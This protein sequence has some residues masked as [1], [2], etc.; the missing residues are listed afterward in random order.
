M[1]K[2][3][4][5]LVLLVMLF[6]FISYPKAKGN[7]RITSVIE[8]EKSTT[9]EVIGNPNYN[10]LNVSFN[11]RF[12]NLN[13]YIKYKIVI[14]NDDSK[15]YKISDEIEAFQPSKYITY[16]YEFDNDNKMISPNSEKVLYVTLT[17]KNEVPEDL[18]IE[19]KTKKTIKEQLPEKE[20]GS[21]L[22]KKYTEQNHLT[23]YL[24]SNDENPNTGTNIK[25]SALIILLIISTGTLIIL[26]TKKKKKI[27]ALI[28][29]CSILSIPTIMKALD[30]D[31][32]TVNTSIEI[33]PQREITFYI[34]DLTAEPAYTYTVNANNGDNF[35]EWINSKYN[36][37]P[38]PFRYE[39][40][41]Y[42]YFEFTD[43]DNNIIVNPSDK[44][45]DKHTYYYYRVFPVY[46]AKDED[47]VQELR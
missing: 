14:K 46:E 13:D 5:I 38:N 47:K 37:F 41:R 22:Y 45:K 30:K 23:I 26:S 9:T 20:E 34:K 1:K 44:I 35:I 17:Y 4:K 40:L 36:N 29:L 18:L 42:L 12:R 8:E 21:P 3:T 25:I 24:D 31:K 43:E 7:I 39:E 27:V 10:D 32:I 11:A 28:L 33:D 2:I 19:E 16:E 15:E 6:S